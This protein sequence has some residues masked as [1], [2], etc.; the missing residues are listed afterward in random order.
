MITES[1]RITVG[2][3]S[4]DV[5]RKDIKNLHL[6]VYPP[7]GRVR[8]AAPLVVSNEAVRLAVIDKLGWIKRQRKNFAAQ[9]RQCEREMVNGETHY[10]FG[11]KYRLRVVERDETPSVAIRGLRGLDLFVRPGADAEKRREVLEDW[12]R[13]EL[14]QRLESLIE[15]WQRVLKAKLSSWRITKMRTRWG[16]CN[17]T[18]RR[19][20]FNLELAKA[21]L[22]CLDYIV[23]HELAHL[24]VRT[25]DERFVKILDKH[26]PDW[27]HRRELL[28]AQTLSVS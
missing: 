5:I 17:S 9:P 21:P 1:Y 4:V 16:G 19:A 8:V 12:Y 7:N 25:H 20:W 27:R 2:G 10:F 15:K 6:G 14:R 28:N 3:I 13:A 23:L 26:M 22:N 18:A 11:Q 24:I